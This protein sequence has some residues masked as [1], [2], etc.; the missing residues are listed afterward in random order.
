MFG[1]SNFI[2]IYFPW[3]DGSRKSFDYKADI[4]HLVIPYRTPL[5]CC[6]LR[7]LF[8]PAFKSVLILIPLGGYLFTR[9]N[10]MYT[11]ESIANNLDERIT[12]IR[13]KWIGP[14]ISSFKQ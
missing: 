8:G 13:K 12:K 6:F 2:H 7:K 4:S 1:Q 9:R 5:A 14:P 10:L 3:D 11:G